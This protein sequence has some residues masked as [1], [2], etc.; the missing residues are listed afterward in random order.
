MLIKELEKILNFTYD[1]CFFL[2]KSF[3]FENYILTIL[4]LT[5]PKIFIRQSNVVEFQLD[6]KY[7][8]KVQEYKLDK[9]TKLILKTNKLNITILDFDYFVKIASFINIEEIEIKLE[10]LI[11][12][13]I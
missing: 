8:Y 10:E 6:F 5:D 2:E 13:N 1:Q 3:V 4:L 7:D 12:E 11:L 9:I